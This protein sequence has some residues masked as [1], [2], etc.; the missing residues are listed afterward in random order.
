MQTQ[1]QDGVARKVARDYIQQTK[2]W[3]F[4]EFQIEVIAHKDDNIVVVDAIHVEDSRG[5]EKGPNK[6]VQLHVNTANKV[7]V[8][9]LAYQ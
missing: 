1:Q 9:E 8:K 6:S 4:E 7:V 3:K 2:K 5:T